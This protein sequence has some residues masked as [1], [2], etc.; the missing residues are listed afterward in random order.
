MQVGGRPAKW[1][2]LRQGLVSS[3]RSY[4][5]YSERGRTSQYN[6][7]CYPREADKIEYF[8]SDI[9]KREDIHGL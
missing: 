8:R 3:I 7:W 2:P 5:F 6:G 1:R 4:S 9:H